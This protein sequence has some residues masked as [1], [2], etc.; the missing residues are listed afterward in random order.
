MQYGMRDILSDALGRSHGDAEL[1]KDEFWAVDGV[2]AHVSKGECLGLIGANGAG[3]STLLKMLN[4]IIRPDRGRITIRGRV[5]ALIEVGAGF[6]PLLTGRE[7]IFI[8]AAILGM[9]RQEVAE[10]L[11]DIIAFA[12]LDQFIDT[13]VKFYSSGMYVRLGFAVAAHVRPEIML[14]DEVLKPVVRR[15]VQRDSGKPQ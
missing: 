5:G 1:R 2:R 14:V 15:R 7:N 8:N 3:K 11:D 10:R 4:G 13:P 6:H 12:E 9:T